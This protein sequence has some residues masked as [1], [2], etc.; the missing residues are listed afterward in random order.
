MQLSCIRSWLLQL[1]LNT[2]RLFLEFGV[3]GSEI[4]IHLIYLTLSI[5]RLNSL[6][7]FKLNPAKVPIEEKNSPC[8]I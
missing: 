6:L 5:N 3:E 4:Q 8:R 2:N 1:Q 7:V